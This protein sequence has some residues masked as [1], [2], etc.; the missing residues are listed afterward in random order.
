M[1]A[2]VRNANIDVEVEGDDREDVLEQ[3][4]RDY[5]DRAAE[6]VYVEWEL[7]LDGGG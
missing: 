5:P 6:T 7:D 4:A 2:R 3:F 1:R